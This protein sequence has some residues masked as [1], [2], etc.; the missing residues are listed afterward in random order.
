MFVHEHH[1]EFAERGEEYAERGAEWCYPFAEKIEIL[2]IINRGKTQ[3][4]QIIVEENSC[5]I[6]S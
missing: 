4:G 6:T 3:H 1:E 2:L 5:V